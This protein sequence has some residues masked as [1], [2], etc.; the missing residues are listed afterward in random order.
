MRL[1]L[2][3]VAALFLGILVFVYLAARQANPVMLP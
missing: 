2:G 3:L 1:F